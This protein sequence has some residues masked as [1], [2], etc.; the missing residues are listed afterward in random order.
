MVNRA[1]RHG[2][3]LVLVVIL[4]APSAYAASLRV[5]VTDTSGKPVENAVVYAVPKDPT[6][7]TGLQQAPKAAVIDQVKKE[8]VKHVTAVTVGT[9][10]LF[11]NNDKIRHH[12][13]SFSPAKVFE[14]QLYKDELPDQV[15]FD[16]PGVVVL[17][18]NIHDWMLAYVFVTDTPYFAVT[19]RAGRAVVADLPAG[20]Y[21]IKVWHAGLKVSGRETRQKMSLAADE[22]RTM[23]IQIERQRLWQ[24]QRAPM[25]M[26]GGY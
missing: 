21:D 6:A 5:S 7:E 19:G 9:P 23:S 12:V 20:E 24:V 25:S 26:R 18:C 3:L 2:W 17:G 10:V 14:I 8:F 4:L 15:V 13:Y 22:R 1:K 11:P 16:K